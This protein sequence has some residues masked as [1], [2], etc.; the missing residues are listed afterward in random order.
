M[1][2]WIINK[3]DKM[4]YTWE[5]ERIIVKV[6]E[7]VARLYALTEN[8]EVSVFLTDNQYIQ[9]LNHLYRGNNYPTDVLSFAMQEKGLGE[10]DFDFPEDVNILG[11]IV[12]SLEKAGEQCVAYSHS[13]ERELGYLV[14][15]GFLHL[16]GYDHEEEQAKI[17]MREMEERV[18]KELHLGR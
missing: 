13:L 16:L 15:H 2:T 14:V 3:Q 7:T 10:P 12:I 9:E 5:L 1:E 17:K 18:L 11:D 8:S 6:T 4:K